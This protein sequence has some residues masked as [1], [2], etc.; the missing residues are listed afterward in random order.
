MTGAKEPTVRIQKIRRNTVKTRLI[1]FGT[2]AFL[3]LICSIF[4]KQQITM[5]R[6]MT[7]LIMR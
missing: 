4:P 5:R 1:I 6:K 3:L 2:L 7:I